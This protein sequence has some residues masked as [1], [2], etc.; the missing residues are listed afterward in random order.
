MFTTQ[1]KLSASLHTEIFMQLLIQLGWALGL[2]I[3]IHGAP[4]ISQSPD[5]PILH[6][7][8]RFDEYFK[9]WKK[10][11]TKEQNTQTKSQKCKMEV[12]EL[13]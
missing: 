1:K 7:W 9:T 2:G 4:E 13:V 11:P 3:L 5:A 8:M 12:I 10:N 6:S